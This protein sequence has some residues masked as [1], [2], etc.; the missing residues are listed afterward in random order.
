MRLSLFVVIAAK[1]RAKQ[2]RSDSKA[3]AKQWQS[4]GKAMAKQWQSV[5]YSHGKRLLR[6][7]EAMVVRA[8]ARKCSGLIVLMQ[9]AYALM[10]HRLRLLVQRTLKRAN[11]EQ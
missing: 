1:G 11:A 9:R 8:M 10:Q 3:V 4:N 6:S 5:A 2:W 7:R